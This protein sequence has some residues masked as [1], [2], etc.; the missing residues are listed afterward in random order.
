[1][2]PEQHA[3]RALSML[4]LWPAVLLSA[5]VSSSHSEPIALAMLRAEAEVR[6]L[7]L[8]YSTPQG[9]GTARILAAPP[10]L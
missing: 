10:T 2:R 5:P 4:A 9:A 7:P 8:D 6:N 3:A 1:M